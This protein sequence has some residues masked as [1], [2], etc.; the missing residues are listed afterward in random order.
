MSTDLLAAIRYMRRPDPIELRALTADGRLSGFFDAERIADVADDYGDN[1]Y[2]TLNAVVDRE[3][4]NELAPARKGGCTQRK[5]VAHYCNIALDFDPVRPT[6][7]PSTDAEH[8]AAIALA[9]TVRD[10]L[11]ASAFPDPMVLS[12]GNGA[13]LIYPADLPAS[14]Y[15]LVQKWTEFLSEKFS[16]DAVK[17]DPSVWR[18]EQV[19]RVPGTW[20]MKGAATAERPHRQCCVLA[21]PLERA[22]VTAAD[23]ARIVPF[24]EVDDKTDKM[25]TTDVDEA[26]Q[27]EC[28]WLNSKKVAYSIED[29]PH[30]KLLRFTKCP[31]RQED[32]GRAW[33]LVTQYGT[34][35]GCFHAKCQGKGIAELRDVFGHEGFIE[36]TIGAPRVDDPHYLAERHREA[37]AH[38]GTPTTVH[39]GEDLLTWK[40]GIWTPT[41]DRAMAPFVAATVKAVF[42]ERAAEI[43]KRGGKGRPLPVKRG[44]VGDTLAAIKSLSRVDREDIPPFWIGEHDW[45]HDWQHQ[46]QA[47]DCVPFRN[48]ILHVPSWLAG[49]ECFRP[50]TPQLFNRHRL[51]FDFDPNAPPPQ[52]WLRFLR[53]LWEDEDCHDLLH[54]WGGLACLTLDT[55]HQK[56]MMMHGK[57]RSGKGTIISIFAA[58]TGGNHAAQNLRGA[59]GEFGLAPLLGKQLWIVPD[60]RETSKRV[61]DESVAILKAITGEDPVT[62][63]VKN[64]PQVTCK[65][66]T[67]IVIPSNE[68]VLF[69]DGSEAL[70]ARQLFLQFDRSFLGNEDLTLKT[71][72][73]AELPGICN[74]F[75]DGLRRLRERGTFTEPKT[76]TKLRAKSNRAANPVNAFVADCC[77]L[78]PKAE[79][80]TDKLYRAFLDWC[81]KYDESELDATSFGRALRPI[82]VDRTRKREDDKRTYFYAGIRLNDTTS[83]HPRA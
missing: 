75:L 56:M 43:K 51:A 21:L 62:I 47:A 74:L 29:H 67:R 57:T 76:S 38:K 17:V 26:T 25:P 30:G 35:A 40:S 58:M 4:T 77:T 24:V 65:L 10:Y 20:N 37:W 55:S 42:D 3:T 81:D 44:I 70:Q 48:G 79:T 72:L 64:K 49:R 33:L 82:G 23:L 54:E 71:Q 52:R 16:T 6:K 50:P 41:S 83:D 11:T 18:P 39:L 12:S 68:L 19:L 9:Y 14:L 7:T 22:E 60:T 32:D 2:W 78:D 28:D 15:P 45:Q 66:S 61:L 5:H 1:L 80:A 34:S 59:L 73:F 8:Q 46:W 27:R 36:S 63:N 13:Y 31:W 69:P 53:E